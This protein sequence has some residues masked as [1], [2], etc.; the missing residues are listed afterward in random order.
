MTDEPITV[1][2]PDSESGG[3]TG[4]PISANPQATTPITAQKNLVNPATDVPGTRGIEYLATP[5]GQSQSAHSIGNRQVS[6]P[7]VALAVTSGDITR[8]QK[9]AE[10]S[11]V[12]SAMD[13]G[14]RNELLAI[15]VKMLGEST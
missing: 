13:D 4:G 2:T 11:R 14:Q 9:S 7:A 12:W 10:L 5:L 8:N 6:D 15:A 1:Q 3:P